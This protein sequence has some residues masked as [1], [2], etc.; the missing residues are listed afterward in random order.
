M[1][2]VIFILSAVI[3]TGASMAGNKYPAAPQFVGKTLDGREI[4]L[5]DYQGKVVLLDFWAS[6]CGPCKQEFPFL[7]ELHRRLKGRNFTVLAINVDTEVAKMQAFLAGQKQ[8]PEFPIIS[9]A[10]GKIPPLFDLQGMP[11]TVLIDQ[12]GVV[13]YRHTGFKEQDKQAIIN[14]IK[15]L[16]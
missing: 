9:D 15:K 10:K 3:L 5:A 2:Q 13:R 14:E 8:A 16:L 7:V 11:T 6:W 1:K 12:N 4:R